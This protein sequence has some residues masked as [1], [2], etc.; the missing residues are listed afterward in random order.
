MDKKYLEKQDSENSLD[1]EECVRNNH[2]ILRFAG[3]SFEKTLVLMVEMLD[4][5]Q[6]KEFEQYKNWD[7]VPDKL[8]MK[9][10]V[11]ACSRC[12]RETLEEITIGFLCET[13]IFFESVLL[14]RGIIPFYYS[15][16]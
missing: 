5:Q 8:K 10:Q 2:P 14:S 3:A 15:M 9:F 12:R 1:L 6:G 7:E 16:G 11:T 13:L 4:L